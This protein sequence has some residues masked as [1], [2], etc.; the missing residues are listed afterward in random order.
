M[1]KDKLMPTQKRKYKI[2]YKEGRGRKIK[3]KRNVQHKPDPTVRS[4]PEPQTNF[5]NGQSKSGTDPFPPQAPL[6]H[7][8]IHA[9]G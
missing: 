3:T 8:R 4:A 6:A 1:R 7:G 2:T 5:V 9:E